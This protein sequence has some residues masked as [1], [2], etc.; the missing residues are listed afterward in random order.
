MSFKFIPGDK[1]EVPEIPYKKSIALPASQTVLIIVDMQ[2]DFV[3]QG[4]SLL[5][6]SALETVPRIQ[7]LLESA[8]DTGVRVVYTQD[9]MFEDDPEWE[10]WPEHC[11]IDTWGWEI[12][13]E[14]KPLSDDLICRKNRY[15]GFYGTWLDHFLSR[16]WKRNN[17]VI[18]GTVS[19]ICVLHTAASAG[20]R[21]YHVV[22]PADG[23]SALTEF[24]QALTLRQVS[25]LYTGDVLKSFRDLSFEA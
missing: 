12:I 22:M 20:L 9:T 24:D 23:I 6:P 7:G 13:D 16:V 10:I 17:L 3:K 14:L 25:S 5:V 4:G 8:R 1:V 15:D 19:N 21:W 11:R 2:N 18:V